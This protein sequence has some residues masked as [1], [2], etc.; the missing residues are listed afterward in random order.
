M[1]FAF[2]MSSSNGSSVLCRLPLGIV[3][4]GG[5]RDHG[6]GD[7]GPE[8]LLGILSDLGEDHGRDFRRLVRLSVDPDRPVGPHV[9][10]DGEDGPIRIHRGLPAG[11]V[12]HELLSLLREGNH[13]GRGSSP[14]AG[15]DDDGVSILHDSSAAVCG[16][17]INADDCAHVQSFLLNRQ[18]GDKKRIQEGT[19]CSSSASATLPSVNRV[20]IRPGKDPVQGHGGKFTK[21]LGMWGQV[22]RAKHAERRMAWGEHGGQ[23]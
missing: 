19:M 17:K 10:L 2:C 3:E 18:R 22:H 8:K 11:D 4:V 1:P 14:C 13:R 6:L 20:T 7:A 15:G 9:A 23:A 12:F 5:N 21:A 16:A